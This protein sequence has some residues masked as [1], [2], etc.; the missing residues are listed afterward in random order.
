MINKIGIS[1]GWDCYPAMEGVKLKIR[2]KK[3]EGYL[4]C[5][6]DKMVSSLEGIIKCIDDDFDKFCDSNYLTLVTV[7]NNIHHFNHLKNNEKLLINNYYNFIFNHESP[8][9]ADLYISENW[10]GG[11]NHYI[12]NDFIEFKKRY[13]QRI[14]NFKNYLNSKN[15]IIFL[16]NRYNPDIDPNINKLKNILKIKYPSLKYD[17]HFFN[18]LYDPQYIKEHLILAGC[19][20]DSEEIKHLSNN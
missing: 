11:I 16:L 2:Q 10:N 20:K 18:I 9:H 19:D 3:S 14:K 15:E 8:G 5:P 7:P 6:F 12:D 1:L 4:T 13:Q 17:F